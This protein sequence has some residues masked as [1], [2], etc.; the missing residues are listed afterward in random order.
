MK[1]S[2]KNLSDFSTTLFAAIVLLSGTAVFSAD[3]DEDERVIEE[4]REELERRE[5][6]YDWAKEVQAP[7]QVIMQRIYKPVAEASREDYERNMRLAKSFQRRA[8]KAS[9][10]RME[11]T[12]EKYAKVARLFYQLAQTNREI[13]NAVRKHDGEKLHGA[14]EEVKDAEHKIMDIAGKRP[15]RE[16]FLP[17]ELRGVGIAADEGDD[18][19]RREGDRGRRDAPEAGREGDRAPEAGHRHGGDRDRGGRHPEEGRDRDR[20]ADEGGPA[21]ESSD[22]RH[23]EE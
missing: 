18:N 14:F 1:A 3:K 10:Q 2:R 5:K 15:E 11:E 20:P 16:W 23:A 4:K 6:V 9:K 7:Q 21:A 22:A 12:A 13:Y 17:D 8:E 19:D